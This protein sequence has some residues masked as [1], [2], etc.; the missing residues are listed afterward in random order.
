MLTRRRTR[1]LGLGK[2]P[3]GRPRRANERHGAANS[4]R[5]ATIVQTNQARRADMAAILGG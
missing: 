3:P 4:P 5:A 1:T 2:G